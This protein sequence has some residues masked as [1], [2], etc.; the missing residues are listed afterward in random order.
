M[1]NGII[2]LCGSG[3]VGSGAGDGGR[4]G[5]ADNDGMG[6]VA[7]PLVGT[8]GVAADDRE[9]LVDA[10]SA[11]LR[12]RAFGLFDDDPAVQR[13]VELFGEDFA[14]ADGPLLQQP[15]RGDVGERL[16]DLDVAVVE[17]TAYLGA[18]GRSTRRSLPGG[19]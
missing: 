18:E 10:D 1:G 5:R 2:R 8:P 3:V 14:A 9:R 6:D 16:A 11:G 13:A 17:A 12:H 4:A 15:D 19:G 7:E